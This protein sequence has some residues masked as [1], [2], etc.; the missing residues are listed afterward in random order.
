MSA[1]REYGKGANSVEEIV[2]RALAD[3]PSDNVREAF[4]DI[5]RFES[6]RRTM[7]GFLERGDAEAPKSV[8]SDGEREQHVAQDGEGV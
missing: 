7:E 3:N 2:Q 8:R 4:D 6:T 5:L 1:M